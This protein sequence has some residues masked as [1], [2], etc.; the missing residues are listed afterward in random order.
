M[1]AYIIPILIIL[2]LLY[3]LIKKINAYKSFTK[4]ALEGAK[5]VLDIMPFIVA[6]MLGVELMRYS[7]ATDILAKT[8]SPVFA[9][10]GV[11]TELCEFVLLRPFS[12]AGSLA[13]LED[14]M[15][16]F[17]PDS[18][19]TR[20]ACTIMGTGETVFYVSAI[21]FSQIG[22]KKITVALCIALFVSFVSV[23]LSCLVCRFI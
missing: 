11:P 12:G 23:I 3:A 2:L 7:G 14:I 19:I 17:G 15:T 21:Y 20:V 4:G 8:L 10:L 5:L 22:Q 13:L 16:T 9:F 18:Y 6:I 1:S